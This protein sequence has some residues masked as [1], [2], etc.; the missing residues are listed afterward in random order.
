MN[1]GTLQRIEK[2]ERQRLESEHRI[3]WEDDDGVIVYFD[4]GLTHE[5]ALAMLN[6]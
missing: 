1:R 6:G 5:E 4:S 3:E 2:I